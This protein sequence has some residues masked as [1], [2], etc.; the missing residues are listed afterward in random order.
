MVLAGYACFGQCEAGPNV[1]FYPEGRWFGGLSSIGAAQMVAA[2]AIGES[3]MD[4]VPL[5]LPAGERDEHLRN[6]AELVGT[7]EADRLRRASGRR[8]W[9]F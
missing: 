9:P 5:D 1:L 7:L 2:H 3:A 6:V 4:G 8:W